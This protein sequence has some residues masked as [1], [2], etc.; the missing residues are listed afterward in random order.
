MADL[1]YDRHVQPTTQTPVEKRFQTALLRFDEENSRDPNFE[2]VNG[3]PHPRELAYSKRLTDWV[4]R[5][6]P[7]ASE[8]LRLAARCQH[9]C[10]WMI[11]R[12]SFPMT[13]S[14]YLQ[15]RQKL[16]QF[17]AERSGEILREVGYPEDM[18]Q[19]VQTLNLKKT[20]SDPETQT[21]EDALCLVFLEHQFGELIDKSTEEK[22]INA[23]Q[24]SWAKMSEAGR[25]EALKLNY[26]PR[27]K[28]LLEKA[29]AA[30]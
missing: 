1:Q 28:A 14:G 6:N 22:V 3:A 16:K 9:L 21:L 30:G 2:P 18:V 11:P 13:K 19:R 29:L 8:P 27:E 20:L 4:L 24:K 17:H 12:N 26:A 23:V 7:D 15:W 25:A 10:R 5:L